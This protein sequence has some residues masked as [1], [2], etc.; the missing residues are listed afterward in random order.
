VSPKRSELSFLIRLASLED[1]MEIAALSGQL[2]YPAD[3]ASMVERLKDL[4]PRTDQ[5]IFVAAGTDDRLVGWVHIYMR[6]L[7]M[8]DLHAELGG[9]VVTDGAQ[10]QGIGAALLEVA[11]AWAR[12]QGGALMI[13]RSNQ[14]RLR[15]HQ[16]YLRLGY[17]MVKQSLVFHK[18]LL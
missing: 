8:L 15:A 11:E 13:V 7:V 1:A 14:V 12:A 10:G 3:V 4:L 18:N 9:L 6:S 16:F 2:G 5:G 17:E